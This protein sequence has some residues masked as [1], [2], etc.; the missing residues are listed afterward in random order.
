[1]LGYKPKEFAP[2]L[3]LRTELPPPEAREVKKTFQTIGAKKSR[4]AHT[5]SDRYGNLYLILGS[6]IVP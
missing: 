1:M 3:L 5:S 2:G 4:G 6:M